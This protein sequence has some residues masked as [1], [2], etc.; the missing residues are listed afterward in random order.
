MQ[1]RTAFVPS[2]PT[3]CCGAQGTASLGPGR[4]RHLPGLAFLACGARCRW[5]RWLAV[6]CL[7]ACTHPPRGC[8]A[9]CVRQCH[10][11]SWCWHRASPS[12]PPR[13]VWYPVPL[14][15]VVQLGCAPRGVSRGAFH[16]LQGCSFAL[17]L[18]L[19]GVWVH[20]GRGRLLGGARCFPRVAQRCNIVAGCPNYELGPHWLT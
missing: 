1:A 4:V 17:G 11:P 3:R 6:V 10:V 19:T 20:T 2:H 7:A 15:Q 13:R 9:G 8:V 16:L 18:R 14:C 12:A 5:H